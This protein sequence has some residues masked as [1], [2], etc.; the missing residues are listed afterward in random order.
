MASIPNI[1]NID[2]LSDLTLSKLSQDIIVQLQ[3]YIYAIIGIIA[4]MCILLIYISIMV[5]VVSRR[6]NRNLQRGR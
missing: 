2:T 5:T 4:T 6:V 3:P 1:G